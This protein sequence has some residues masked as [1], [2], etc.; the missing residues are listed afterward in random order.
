MT[1]RFNIGDKVRVKQDIKFETGS[2][3]PDVLRTEYTYTVASVWGI[4]LKVNERTPNN[5]PQFN[6]NNFYSVEV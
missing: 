1:T 6:P 5:Q 4:F 3:M 2:G